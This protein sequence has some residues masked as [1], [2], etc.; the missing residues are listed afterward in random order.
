MGEA[1]L[2]NLERHHGAEK[3]GVSGWGSTLYILHDPRIWARMA[4]SFSGLPSGPK[5]YTL[6]QNLSFA[7]RQS[8]SGAIC[9]K[10]NSI[11][12]SVARRWRGGVVVPLEPGEAEGLGGVVDGDDVGEGRREVRCRLPLPH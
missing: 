2:E 3:R 12:V 5:P 10:W 11:S 4:D 9:W 1:G 6:R 7:S 8:I